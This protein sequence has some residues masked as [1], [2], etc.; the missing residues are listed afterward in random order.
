MQPM[1][2]VSYSDE[3]FI[4]LIMASNKLRPY[5]FYIVDSFGVMKRKDLMRLYYLVDHNLDKDIYVGYHSHNNIQMAYSNAQALVDLKTKRKLII[6]SSV[7]GMGRGA[8]NLNTEL[9]IDYLNE[10]NGDNYNSKPLLQ[11]IDQILAPVYLNNYWGYSLPHYISAIYNC[12]PNYASYLDNKN[13]LTIENINEIM[14]QLDDN[15]KGSF[16]K[17]YIERLYN[18]YQAKIVADENARKELKRSLEGKNVVLI[19]PGTSINK[20]ADKIIKAIKKPD[21]VVISINFNPDQ[22][23]CDYIFVS[24]LR[25]YQDLKN[26]LGTKLIATS[27]II[28]GD[29]DGYVVN[30]SDL[31][32]NI[33]AVKDNA[34]MML[35]ALLIDLGVKN[36]KLAGL[37]GYSHNLYENFAERD[38]A[39]IKSNSVMD[40]MN[41]GM[42]K[43]LREFSGI[44]NIEFVT[45]P[46]YV[47]L[48][49]V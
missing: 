20:E 42:E 4:Q 36:V 16:D 15:K 24:N 43:L 33:E 44:I 32:N 10:V 7:F 2:S 5:A 23:A 49:A 39:F 6:D 34:S 35:I 22:F 37:D 26:N 41:I 28:N 30:Y 25:R 12:H 29:I 3:E 31:L 11:I 27:N 19:A 38:M 18:Q 48:G 9:F 45:T 17:G 46:K 40:A 47:K 21:T 8:G 1:V 13:T 14:R